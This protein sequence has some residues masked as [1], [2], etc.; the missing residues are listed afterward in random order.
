MYTNDYNKNINMEDQLGK[1]LRKYRKSYNLNIREFAS[2][3]DVSYSLISKYENGKR[4]PPSTFLYRLQNRLLHLSS[5]GFQP[6]REFQKLL[7]L[8]NKK[9]VIIKNIENIDFVWFVD[10]K[11]SDLNFVLDEQRGVIN[12]GK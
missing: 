5:R 7:E 10:D 11:D 3:M 8:R 1:R 6:S 2:L 4:K 9:K 12:Y